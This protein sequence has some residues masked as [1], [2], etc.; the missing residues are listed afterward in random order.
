MTTIDQ[1]E[2]GIPAAPFIANVQEFV[3]GRH[4]DTL[5]SFQEML[6]KY[7]FM[8]RHLLQRQLALAR[9]TPE[10][11]ASRDWLPLLATAQRVDVELGDTLLVSAAVAPTATVGLWLGANVMLEFPVAE[12]REL[13]ARKLASAETSQRQV[14]DDLAFLKTQITTMQ[15]N[16]ARVYNDSVQLKRK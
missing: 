3:Q 12:A 7:Q 6:Q 1:N 10:I 8:E 2:R 15:V 13:L 5:R 4:Q 11:R 9:K 16:M 14:H